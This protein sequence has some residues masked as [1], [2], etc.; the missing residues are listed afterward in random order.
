MQATESL[1]NV[2]LNSNLQRYGGD[3]YVGSLTIIQ[4][5]MQLIIVPVNGFTSGVQPIISYNYGAG[6]F[7]RVKKTYRISLAVAF[8]AAT[9]CC[10]GTVSF[11]EFFAGLFTSNEELIVL[12]ASV[13]PIYLGSVWIFGIQMACQ[14]AFVGLGQA[15]KSLFVA[16][17]RKVFLLT[18][19]AIFL[20]MKFGVMGIYY[21]EPI[22]TFI[23]AVT[24]GVLF[25]FTYRTILSPG[26]REV[27]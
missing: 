11:P 23:S 17:L 21:S 8:S 13:M 15:G 20:P 22:A 1:I 7:D 19:L 27:A 9:I 16:L 4:S 24:A 18:P 14:S 12:A 10:I 5:V 26:S 2:V 25:L 3:L 6:N